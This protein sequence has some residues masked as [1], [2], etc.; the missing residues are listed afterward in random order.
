M[1]EA[2]K[3]LSKILEKSRRKKDEDL[4]GWRRKG[5][6]DSASGGFEPGAANLSP[7]WFAQGHEVRMSEQLH[8]SY[9]L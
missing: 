3:S 7:G 1:N 8:S 2:M 4:A 9:L 6:R 5:F